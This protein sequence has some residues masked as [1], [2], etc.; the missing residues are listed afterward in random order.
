MPGTTS[1]P[2]ASMTSAP[3]GG[4]GRRNALD[5]F[6]ADQDVGRCR[7]VNVAA[8]IV[9]ASAADQS[10]GGVARHSGLPRQSGRAARI[11]STIFIGVSGTW[12]IRTL[13]GVSA[14]S[15]AEISAA[16]AGMVP[17]SPTPL[18]PSGLSG[19]GVSL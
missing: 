8:V 16:A 6:A 15:T 12:P 5:R 17:A 4:D 9:D 2:A 3:V 7:L 1:L 11:I 10:T 14:S 13:N 19:E 18:T